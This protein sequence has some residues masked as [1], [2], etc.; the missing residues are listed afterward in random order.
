MT[1]DIPSPKEHVNILM[2][3]LKNQQT[4]LAS[5]QKV[6]E[7]LHKIHPETTAHPTLTPNDTFNATET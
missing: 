4:Y 7:I 5:N 3:H 1:N 6:M 2:R